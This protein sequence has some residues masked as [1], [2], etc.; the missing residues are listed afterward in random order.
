MTVLTW[1]LN[2]L[3]PIFDMIAC[4]ILY[5]IGLGSVL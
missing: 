3:T 1:D 2:I 5:L 4:I